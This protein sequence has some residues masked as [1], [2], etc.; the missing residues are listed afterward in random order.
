VIIYDQFQQNTDL[1]SLARLGLPTAS[2]FSTVMA[3]GRSDSASKTRGKYISR[4]A[5]ELYTG[6]P[7]TSGYTNAYMERGK[8]LE[9]EALALYARTHKVDHVGFV[10][11]DELGVGPIGCSPDGLVGTD[12][13]V[14]VKSLIPELMVD[15]L[16]APAIPQEHLAQVHGC[17]LVTGRM[18]W[19][20]AI[21]CPGF[22]LYVERVGRETGWLDEIKRFLAP[23]Q[24]E[25]EQKI[26]RLTKEEQTW[27][28]LR[29]MRDA[30]LNERLAEEEGK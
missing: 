25:L 27:K 16:C 13:G 15:L 2:C 10:R 12:G 11:N 6:T 30:Y 24:T 26:L 3:K 17:L 28:G 19:D 21:Y 20:V 18:W 22:E 8:L 5:A 1:W 29:K 9:P 14:E 4:L 23:F 7:V